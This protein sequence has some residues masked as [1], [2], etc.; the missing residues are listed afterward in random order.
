MEKFIGAWRLFEIREPDSETGLE[1]PA[2][3]QPISAMGEQRSS[4]TR[5][6]RLLPEAIRKWQS[7]TRLRSDPPS[8]AAFF[9]GAPGCSSPA[10]NN[11][12]A[13]QRSFGG[14]LAL[15]G[16]GDGRF[17]DLADFSPDQFSITDERLGNSGYCGP[18]LIREQTFL[19]LL[20]QR[21]QDRRAIC[22]DPSR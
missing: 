15:A 1:K 21:R 20:P 4:A 22:V 8:E 12:C 6:Q 7:K 19:N 18:I 2:S 17:H 13:H 14:V 11:F 3:A 5:G 9:G 16:A 10:A